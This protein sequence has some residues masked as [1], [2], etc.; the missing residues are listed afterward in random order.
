MPPCLPLLILN[1]RLIPYQA[2]SEN[3][4]YAH[5]HA[6]AQP[7]MAT[8][9]QRCSPLRLKVAYKEVLDLAKDGSLPEDRLADCQ[10]G[11]VQSYP[12]S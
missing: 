2:V 3:P 4:S 9:I 5:A 8:G 6:H 1:G 10:F 12:A 11:L 7:S